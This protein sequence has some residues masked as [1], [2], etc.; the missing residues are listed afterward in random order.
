MSPAP[1]TG[2][3]PNSAPDRARRRTP[4]IVALDVPELDQA[5][6]LARRLEGEVGYFKIGLELFAAHGPRA[7][8]TITTYGSVFLDAKL[9]DIP[10]TVRRSARQLG[11][12]GV[13]MLTVHA[14]GGRAMME[15]A[16]TGLAEGAHGSGRPDPLVLAVTVLTSLDDDDLAAMNQ[17]SADEQVPALAKLAL[18]AGAPGLVC[19]PAD[20]GR[21]RG[22][23]GDGLVLVT[24]GIRPAGDDHDDHARAAVPAD[25][26]EAGA[27]YLVIG[28]PI[29]RAADPV[30][31]ARSLMGS[32]ES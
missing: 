30:T 21:V 24:P 13:S 20:L 10:T 1:A 27:D 8:R 16:V 9:H 25:A 32:L 6:E 5:E 17:P 19:A 28:R 29:L 15:A 18:A 14:T 26:I 7:V 22:A 11:R 12:L 2:G 23:V 31:V 3:G 4:L